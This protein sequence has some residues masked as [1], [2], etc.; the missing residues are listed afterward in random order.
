MGC[1]VDM[2]CGPFYNDLLIIV[3]NGKQSLKAFSSHLHN[4]LSLFLNYFYLLWS[5]LPRLWQIEN[6]WLE[7]SFVADWMVCKA[8]SMNHCKRPHKEIPQPEENTCIPHQNICLC[9]KPKE[10]SNMY[11]TIFPQSRLK[12]VF[13][14]SFSK[15]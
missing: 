2:S 3:G 15:K 1:H 14:L 7:F 8:R 6:Q 11:T 10:I 13:R 4:F 12:S 9:P 5:K